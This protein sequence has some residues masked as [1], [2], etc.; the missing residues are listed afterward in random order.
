MYLVNNTADGNTTITIRDPST[1][2][3]CVLP[4]YSRGKA[5]SVAKRA[6]VVE[7]PD[8]EQPPIKMGDTASGLSQNLNFIISD[9]RLRRQV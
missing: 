2:K 6:T 1:G 7:V 8:E 3:R 4:T 9:K 5:P